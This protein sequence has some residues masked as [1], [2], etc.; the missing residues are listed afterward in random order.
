MTFA[1]L[2]PVSGAYVGVLVPAA[3]LLAV[4]FWPRR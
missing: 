1:A 4:A 3:W 2:I